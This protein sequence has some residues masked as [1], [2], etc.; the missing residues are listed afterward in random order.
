[1][2]A[3]KTVL[4]IKR[5]GKIFGGCEIFDFENIPQGYIKLCGAGVPKPKGSRKFP[6]IK[7]TL[8]NPTDDQV[9]EYAKKLMTRSDIFQTNSEKN[10]NDYTFEIVEKNK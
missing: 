2:S 7:N 5:L 10:P 3:Q 1:M 6:H 9:I 8:I 4:K